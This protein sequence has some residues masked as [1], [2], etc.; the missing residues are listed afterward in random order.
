MAPLNIHIT[1]SSSDHWHREKDHHTSSQPDTVGV[2]KGMLP[3]QNYYYYYH[4]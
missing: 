3:G 4:Y 1:F 2:G